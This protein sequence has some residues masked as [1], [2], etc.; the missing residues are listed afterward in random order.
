M[1]VYPLS[2]IDSAISFRLS[3]A[4]AC[5]L[6]VIAAH[7]SL[8]HVTNSE[9]PVYISCLC[10]F[11][12]RYKVPLRVIIIGNPHRIEIIVFRGVFISDSPKIIS[13]ATIMLRYPKSYSSNSGLKMSAEKKPAG[14]I[15]AIIPAKFKSIVLNVM[16]LLFS[17]ST[18]RLKSVE[19]LKSFQ[20]NRRSF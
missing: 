19:N 20:W 11:P 14:S 3:V 16:S 13:A 8:N 5:N 6:D 18:A 2:A 17:P 15:T 4:E 7:V 12:G 10:H 9:L 1:E